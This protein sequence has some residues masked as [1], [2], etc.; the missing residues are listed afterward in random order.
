MA[1]LPTRLLKFDSSSDR[2]ACFER[3]TKTWHP[4]QKAGHWLVSWHTSRIAT[5]LE[6]T[7]SDMHAYK[8]RLRYAWLPPQKTRAR[9]E[10][11]NRENCRA[12]EGV[13]YEVR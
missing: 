12:I 4:S 1:H 5:R 7:E 2:H 8:G 13:Y 3:K 6:G 10:E 11:G 9:R